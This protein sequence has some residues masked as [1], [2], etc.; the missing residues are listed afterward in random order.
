MDAQTMVR[1]QLGSRAVHISFLSQVV[2]DGT[3]EEAIVNT[4]KQSRRWRS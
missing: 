4:A 1:A 2:Q 3:P